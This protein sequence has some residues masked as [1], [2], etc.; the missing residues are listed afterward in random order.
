[1][2]CEADGAALRQISGDETSPA[3]CVAHAALPVGGGLLAIGERRAIVKRRWF[4]TVGL[5]ALAQPAWADDSQS[6]S[7]PLPP[8]ALTT[9]RHSD[10]WKIKN[11]LSAAPAVIAEKATVM[12][13]P[14]EPKNHAHGRILRQGSNG[15]TCMPDEP[16][17][18]QHNPMCVDE[19]MMKWIIASIEGKK[20]NIDR[21]GLSYMLLGEVGADIGD[22]TAKRPPAGKDW[23]YA[24]P[25]VMVVLPDDAA[26]ALRDIN[27]D[28]STNGP[29]VRWLR[30]KG[31]TP[32][33]VIPVAKAGER[34]EVKRPSTAGLSTDGR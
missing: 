20:P 10:E 26:A 22:L 29:Y 2:V 8:G 14:S 23:Y 31:S 33:L 18:P 17:K 13:W 7:D 28:P 4:W 9:S 3:N 16:G 30:Y 34:I 19:T 21:V 32:L 27:R 25:H 1:M 24:G 5:V 15:W 12:D 11:A 6:V